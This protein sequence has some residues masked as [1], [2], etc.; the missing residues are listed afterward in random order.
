[1]ILEIFLPLYFIGSLFWLMFSMLMWR[2]PIYKWHVRAGARG[3]AI[4]PLWPIA[5]VAII[6]YYVGTGF[7]GFF[8]KLYEDAK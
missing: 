6:I 7:K 2:S 5:L 8:I 3:V 1:M 4:F